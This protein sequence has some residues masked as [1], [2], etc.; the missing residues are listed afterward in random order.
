MIFVYSRKQL[1]LYRPQEGEKFGLQVQP[2]VGEGDVLVT[3]GLLESEM[4]GQ[5][6]DIL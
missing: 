5:E 2:V 6:L 4:G 1:A 3:G